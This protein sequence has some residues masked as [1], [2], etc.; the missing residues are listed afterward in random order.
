MN[1]LGR[2]FLNFLN[3]LKTEFF[4]LQNIKV[5]ITYI[6]VYQIVITTYHTIYGR[7]STIEK[8]S[9]LEGFHHWLKVSSHYHDWQRFLNGFFFN[10]LSCIDGNDRPLMRFII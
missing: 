2:I 9:L 10:H 4:F 6:R 5:E 3:D 8:Q 1:V 7:D